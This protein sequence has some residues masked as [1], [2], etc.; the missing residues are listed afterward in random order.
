MQ[1]KQPVKK[2]DGSLLFKGIAPD[3]PGFKRDVDNVKRLIPLK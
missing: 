3:L 2:N 1:R